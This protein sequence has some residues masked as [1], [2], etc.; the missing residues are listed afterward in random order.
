MATFL[1][2]AEVARLIDHTNLKATA[3][4]ADIGRLCEE[5]AEYAFATVCVNP[6]WVPAAK[7]VLE[8]TGVGIATVVGFPLGANLMTTKAFEAGQGVRLGATD[9]DMVLNI[10]ALKSGDSNI[11]KQD[12]RMVVQASEG[13]IVKVILETCYLSKEEIVLAC[14]LAEDAGA[15]FVKTSTGFGSDG[16]TVA[17]VRLMRAAVSQSL[18]VKAAGGIRSLEDLMAMVD[19]GAERIGTSAGVSI[20]RGL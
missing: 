14:R 17:N 20:I 15:H 13:A 19:A 7:K 2:S 3:T 11:V 1:G 6:A 12:I 5:A 9:V 16:A 18:K 4:Q 8:G 10:G